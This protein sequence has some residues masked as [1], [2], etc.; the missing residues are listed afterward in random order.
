MKLKA[1]LG[2][3]SIF[4]ALFAAL[5]E[6]TKK[7]I[8]AALDRL[9]DKFEPGSWEDIGME[10]AVGIIRNQTGIPDYPDVEI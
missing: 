4:K 7:A 6:D 8:D 9:E 3:L 1:I 5:D 2:A 10:F